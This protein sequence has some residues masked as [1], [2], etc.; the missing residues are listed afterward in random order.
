MSQPIKIPETSKTRYLSGITALNIM[1]SAGTGDWHVEQTFFTPHTK[2]GRSFI[3]GDNCETNTNEILGTLGIY[4]CSAILKEMGIPCNEPVYAADHARAIVDML[5]IAVIKNNDL[6][7]IVLDEWMPTTSDK[8]KV[9][10][11]VQG[12]LLCLTDIEQQR[13]L[14]WLTKQT[15]N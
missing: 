11:L 9:I 1:S 4:E 12:V 2:R 3:A 6:S 13:L 10:I 7:G 5:Y 8:N 14:T 15:I